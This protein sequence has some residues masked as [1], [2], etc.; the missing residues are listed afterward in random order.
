V[1]DWLQGLAGT[2]DEGTQT[3][4]LRYDKC[5]N[6]HGDCAAAA[7]YRAYRKVQ[8]R[9][10]VLKSNLDA[11]CARPV[12]SVWTRHRQGGLTSHQVCR[13]VCV[14]VG[15]GGPWHVERPPGA[16]RAV[17]GSDALTCV[18]EVPGSYTGWD[19]D[20]A[21]S[22]RDFRKMPRYCVCTLAMATYRS[23]VNVSTF[24]S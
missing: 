11:F 4:V 12:L 5:P 23:L 17:S 3:L 22:L 21:D 20:C 7:A 13:R 1:Q 15:G 19:S 18:R 6:L 2:F 16:N 8:E 24:S 14:C 10:V 9:Y